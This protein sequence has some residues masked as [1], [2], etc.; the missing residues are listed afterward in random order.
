[1]FPKQGLSWRN[2]RSNQHYEITCPNR[3]TIY[4]KD[5]R[6]VGILYSLLWYYRNKIRSKKCNHEIFFHLADLKVSNEFYEE[7]MMRIIV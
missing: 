7:N 6:G 5:M 3:I 2:I 4:N 1:M